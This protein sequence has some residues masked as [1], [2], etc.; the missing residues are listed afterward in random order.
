MLKLRQALLAA[1]LLLPAA[2][3]PAPA[4]AQ[5]KITIGVSLAQDDNPFYIAMLRGIRARAQELGWEVATVS[6][7][8]DK[9]KQINGVQDLVARGVKGILISPID[10]VG[11]NAAYDAA[12]AA[13]VPIISL[14][15]GSA[16]PNQTAY[17]PMDEKQV[18][19][20]IAS[21]TA[22]HIGD[23]GKV[24]FIGGP[25]GAPTFRNLE[26][27]YSEVMAKQPGI[28]VVFKNDG[29]LT[30]ERGVKQTED[31]LVANPDLKAI[32][33]ANDDV[34]LGAMQAVLAAN[35]TTL[36]T[37]MNGVPPALRAVKDGKMAMTIEPN[38]VLWGRLGVDVLAQYLK[39]DK[40]EP[41]VF[42]KHVIIDKSNI[43]DKLPKT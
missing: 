10:A 19:R 16:S 12:T 3:V 9:V 27:G 35:K 25:A 34:A 2:L 37:G 24:A 21:W 1:A 40:V 20:D 11:V 17:I 5:E 36:V 31:A 7:N 26:Q 15:R 8:E 32:Y 28:Q 38:P 43:D 22:Q 41:R 42:I 18:G 6:A 33:A 29:P 13:K 39:G 14:A 30:R 23:A 4:A